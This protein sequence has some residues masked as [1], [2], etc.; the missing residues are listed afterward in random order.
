M[1]YSFSKVSSE[2]KFVRG[3][4]ARHRTAALDRG[5]RASIAGSSL[6]FRRGSPAAGDPI[7]SPIAEDDAFKAA[8]FHHRGDVRAGKAPFQP[9]TEAIESIGPHRVKT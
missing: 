7:W 1:L 8:A 5:S 6:T 4:N 3:D 9:G 2:I